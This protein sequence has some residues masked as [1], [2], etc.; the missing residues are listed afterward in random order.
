MH[1]TFYGA[2]REVTGSMHMLATDNDRILFD[3]GMFQGRRRESAEKN[4]VIPFDPA[5]IT[6]LVLSHGHIDHSGRIPMLTKNGFSG[7][8]VCTR[9]TAAV[10][11]YLLMDSAHIQES[12]ANY[13]NYKLVRNTLAEMKKSRRAKKISK[14]KLEDIK[15]VLKKSRRELDVDT[16][17]GMIHRYNLDGIEPLYTKFDAEHALTCFDGYPYQHPVTIG[18]DITCTQYE[19]GHILGSAISIVH[20]RE[21]GQ[22]FTIGYSGDLGRFDKPII[23]DPTLEFAEEDRKIDLM[24]MESTYGD[25]VHDPVRDLKPQLQKIIQETAERRGTIIIPAFA[26]GRTQGLLYELHELYDEGAVPRLPVYVDS[27]LATKLTKVYGEHP[28]LYDEETHDTFLE[29]GKNPFQFKQVNFVGSVQESMALNRDENPHIVVS[30]SGM[31]EAG[32][33]LH[34]LRHKVHQSKNTILL[35]GYMAQNT[36]GRRIHDL[37]LEYAANG[38]KGPAPILKFMGKQYPL[39][40]RVEKID[41]FSGH[42]DKK[43]MLRVLK[44]SNLEI[45]RIAL[46]HGEEEQMLAFAEYLRNEGFDVVVPQRGETIS[47]R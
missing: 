37:G 41:G 46:V 5:I 36:L 34:H 32:R 11:E 47:L 15:S 10:C 3:C 31:C 21:N 19:A 1:I 23:G 12:D 45:K 27:P 43:E 8:I 28:E 35:V 40:A 20:A 22:K 30:A 18:Q 42:G 26:F 14:H 44:E 6:N 16:I 33:I 13:L 17:N 29:H 25:R 9:A 2:I 38:R 4:R 24:I 39:N 7:R